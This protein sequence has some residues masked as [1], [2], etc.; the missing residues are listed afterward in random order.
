MNENRKVTI[1]TEIY[2]GCFLVLYRKKK[3]LPSSCRTTVKSLILTSARMFCQLGWNAI[4]TLVQIRFCFLPKISRVL[5]F[6]CSGYSYLLYWKYYYLIFIYASF[7]ALLIRVWASSREGMN[8]LWLKMHN[9][10]SPMG[11]YS[12][13]ALKW[14]GQQLCWLHWHNVPTYMKGLTGFV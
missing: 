13:N 4:S 11:N 1:Y 10:Y 12:V 14:N 9:T 6:A 8:L 3:S 2:V 5:Y 7:T